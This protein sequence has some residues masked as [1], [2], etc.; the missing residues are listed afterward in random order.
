MSSRRIVV[1]T[2][3]TPSLL[4]FRMDMMSDFMK[5]G[6]EVTAVG[7]EAEE[8]W[9][10]EF[11]HYGISYR[12]IP[13]VRNGLNPFQD[14]QTI[15]AIKNL[16]KDIKPE[17]VFLYQAK[18]VV[19]GSIAARED[20]NIEVYSLVSGLGSIFRGTTWKHQ[21]LKTVMK[22]QY[23]YA[24][25]KNA[26]VI[27]HNPD[28]M[29]Q[30]IKWNIVTKSLCRIVPGSGV[31]IEKF[32][33]E[34]MPE[35][36]ISFL[37]ISRMIR[38][39]GVLEY[40]EACKLIKKKF[41]KIKCMLVGPFDTNPSGI[42]REQL[43][44]YMPYVEYYGEQKDVRPFVKKCTT[45]ILPSYHEGVPKSV[46]EAMSMG[47]AIITTDAPGCREVVTDGENGFLVPVK[48]YEQ[49]AERMEHIIAHPEIQK[50]MGKKSR[51]I[52]EATYD[53]NKVDNEIAK[54]MK[55]GRLDCE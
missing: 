15:K 1:I 43:E 28:D 25:S 44:E 13:I 38:D 24:L 36:V 20:S 35:G 34:E 53:V 40:L 27:F 47:R 37:M 45:Y 9:K 54:I 50:G 39:K 55:L 46:L 23:R 49:L 14:M 17:K 5:R 42:S 41:P 16:Y 18:A 21:I 32:S 3:H 48:N 2:P 19:Y 33:Y 8:Q 11:E 31:N 12:A 4:W 30:F 22:W 29:Q 52:V 26:A 7:E 51:E 6:Y 10:D